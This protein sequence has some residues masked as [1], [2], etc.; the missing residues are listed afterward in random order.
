MVVFTE[1]QRKI[2]LKLTRSKKGLSLAE[3]E[4]Q[5]G[6]SQRTL[7]REFAELRLYL[8]QQGVILA[9][10]DG[11]YQVNGSQ[12]AISQ[13]ENSLINQKKTY[14]LPTSSRQNAIVAMLLLSTAEM[15]INELALNLEVSQGT[16]QRDL[17]DVSQSLSAYG[18]LL[19]RKKGV[20]IVVTGPEALRRQLFCRI[21]LSEINEYKFLLSLQKKEEIMDNIFALLIPTELLIKSY[22]S[23]TK[24]VLPEIKGISDR[25]TIS[26]VLIFSL[27]IYRS[28]FG[29]KITKIT[30]ENVEIKYLGLVYKFL[31]EVNH[32]SSDKE[33]VNFLAVQLKN[34]DQQITHDSFDDMDFSISVQVKE[35]ISLVS[36]TYGW[37]FTR[38]PSFFEKLT[39][40]IE[41]LLKKKQPPLPE[42][43]LRSI[44]Q[45]EQKYQDL[46]K[47]I[48]DKWTEVFPENPLISSERQLI[49][50]YFANECESH[51]Y[52]HRLR[53]LVICEN[54]FSTSQIL[55]NRLIQEL[56]E[57]DQVDT[58]KISRLNQIDVA[59]YDLVLTTTDLP[60]FSR[61]YQVV[62]PLLL[63]G[64][65]E[66]IKKY[67]KTYQEKYANLAKNDY[68]SSSLAKLNA[69]KNKIDLYTGITR[70]FLVFDLKN[71]QKQSI[72][73]V[74]N[75]AVKQL[76]KDVIA[77][78]EHVSQKLIKRINLSPIGLPNSHLALVHTSSSA[79][80]RIYVTVCQL[81][82]P[83]KMLGMDDHEIDV[84]RFLIM[85]AP[86]DSTS[87]ELHVLGIISSSLVMNNESIKFFETGTTNQLKE[88]LAQQFLP[89]LEQIK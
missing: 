33:E 55:K 80:R 53:A 23:L 50:L 28:S 72:D 73:Q 6:V 81:T 17:N 54:G 86:D 10:N 24:S 2:L 22:D 12:R 13:I 4:Q 19:N 26:L 74:I 8:E 47:I 42:T 79:V 38:N 59:N 46:A 88:F 35:F 78:C 84:D 87:E 52:G 51:K 65:V 21:V 27:T 71:K 40:H 57:I 69:I 16:I 75:K 1:R 11:I 37:D 14:R 67:L 58:T 64:E 82:V 63:N 48:D 25:Q 39:D 41:S 66:K 3:I 15:K 77:D 31:S 43:N 32:Q 60:G 34:S 68:H 29:C 44:E 56:P 45:M 49:L 70:D 89:I 61:E 5:L 85:L 18:L 83:L 30:N 76:P 20:G 9:N 62:S 36:T 7:Y